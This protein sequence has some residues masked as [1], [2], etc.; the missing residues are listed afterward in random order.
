MV[1]QIYSSLGGDFLL[2][3]HSQP[4]S[5]LLPGMGFLKERATVNARLA[6]L[7]LAIQGACRRC[8]K[9]PTPSLASAKIRTRS[10]MEEKKFSLSN[11]QAEYQRS[12]HPRLSNCQCFY[13]HCTGE[14]STP[15]VSVR[16][17]SLDDNVREVTTRAT[18]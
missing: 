8:S 1:I 17:K 5:N 15:W 4:F 7:R 6:A 9:S 2:F 12:M 16:V 14:T 10:Y 11:W 18:P 3:A 13:I